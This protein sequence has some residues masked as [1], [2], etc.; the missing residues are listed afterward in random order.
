MPAQLP[1][2]WTEKDQESLDRGRSSYDDGEWYED[3]EPSFSE[4]LAT[5]FKQ[6]GGSDATADANEQFE[7]Q[8]VGKAARGVL[9]EVPG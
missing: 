2:S 3:G 9:P 1:S 8:P 6:L 4:R 7:L 5:G